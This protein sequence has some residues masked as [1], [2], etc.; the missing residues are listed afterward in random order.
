MGFLCQNVGEIDFPSSMARYD[1]HVTFRNI[2]H[3]FSSASASP[4][5]PLLMNYSIKYVSLW[6]WGFKFEFFIPQSCFLHRHYHVFV[7]HEA[8]VNLRRGE[9]LLENREPENPMSSLCASIEYLR[10]CP[11]MQ[12]LFPGFISPRMCLDP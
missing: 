10:C 6:H 5:I 7:I 8:G 12:S 4:W 11:V 3:M 2:Q 9:I 1:S